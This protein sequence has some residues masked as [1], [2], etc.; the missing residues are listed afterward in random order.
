M[1]VEPSPPEELVKIKN[2]L[3]NKLKLDVN[4]IH[5]RKDAIHW[6]LST[7]NETEILLK[8]RRII[9]RGCR[10]FIQAL[11]SKLGEENYYIFFHNDK[12]L[13]DLKFSSFLDK[14]VV[15][16]PLTVIKNWIA[17]ININP[18]KPYLENVLGETLITEISAKKIIKKE[19]LIEKFIAQAKKFGRKIF[20]TK[21]DE[22]VIEGIV[23][24]LPELSF[25][26]RIKLLALLKDK[27]R[28]KNIDIYDLLVARIK[29][30]TGEEV[31][32]IIKNLPQI[33]LTTK[34]LKDNLKKLGVFE[35][36]IY[37]DGVREEVLQRF[38]EENPWIFG[39]EYYS[40]LKPQTSIDP[41]RKN[42]P[43][44]ILEDILK[45]GDG[46]FISPIFEL[47]RADVEV[48]KRDVRKIGEFA[49]RSKVMDAIWQAIR[50]YDEQYKKGKYPKV[51]III[52]RRKDNPKDIE[53]VLTKLNSHLPNIHL[54]TYDTLIERSKARIDFYLKSH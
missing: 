1:K 42:V 37:K 15:F 47:K 12:R 49:P 10:K 20:G 50:Y 22:K 21:E 38:L 4:I 26:E 35:K 19:S 5:G 17:Q 41:S 23:K 44:F 48:L 46:Y 8:G 29:E 2:E 45:R 9:G 40:S 18:N 13:P 52:G 3:K 30:A 11:D 34:R 36:T 53:K 28:L 7:L 33:L 51:F 32:E 14:K 16:I 43:D 54:I 6:S 25:D 31:N 24:K 39:E 27:H